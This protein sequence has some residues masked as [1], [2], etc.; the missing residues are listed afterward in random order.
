MQYFSNSFE[1]SVPHSGTTS[2]GLSSHKGTHKCYSTNFLVRKQ[3]RTT[4]PADAIEPN[5]D[6]LVRARWIYVVTVEIDDPK[7]PLGY[8]VFEAY[9]CARCNFEN[10]PIANR[11]PHSCSRWSI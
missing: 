4:T 9:H 7:G 1:D 11:T 8:E 3:A 6:P 10:Q 2:E 5:S